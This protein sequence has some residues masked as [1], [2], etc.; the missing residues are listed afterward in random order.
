E[1]LLAPGMAEVFLEVL[2]DKQGGAIF[3]LLHYCG[4]VRL[5][6]R[7]DERVKMF[8]HE[9]VSY[10]LE[11]QLP[12]QLSPSHNPVVFETLGIKQVRTPIRAVGQIMQVIEAV[13]ML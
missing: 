2:Q 12:P 7:P 3:K 9:D 8:G 10:D 4:R 5:R 11:S 6:R 13:I 1:H